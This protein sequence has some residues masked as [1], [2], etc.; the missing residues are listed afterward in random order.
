MPILS[1]RYFEC[2]VWHRKNN[3]NQYEEVPVTFRA[4]IVSDVNS[5]KNQIMPG[6]NNSMPSLVIETIDLDKVEMYDKIQV[7]DDVYQVERIM[8]KKTQSPYTM[9]AHKFNNKHIKEKLP[10]VIYLT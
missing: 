2:K 3:S 8:T 6:I 4:K 9:G 1:G 10:K 5:S 7:L